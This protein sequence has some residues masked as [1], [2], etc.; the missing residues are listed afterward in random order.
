VLAYTLL[1]EILAVDAEGGVRGVS[2]EISDADG[3]FKLSFYV[4]PGARD[5]VH[6]S[7]NLI[8]S[9][10]YLLANRYP[11]FVLVARA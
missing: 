7:V 9:G 11:D 4:N 5:R 2:T 10:F 1:N 8:L 3:V 6:N